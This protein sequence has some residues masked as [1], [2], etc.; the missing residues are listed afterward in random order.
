MK[1]NAM[2]DR[3]KWRPVFEAE[4]VAGGAAAPAPEPAAPEAPKT[5]LSDAFAGDPAKTAQAAEESKDA[6]ADEGKGGD[7]G[8]KTAAEAEAAAPFEVSVP[9]GMESHKDAFTGYTGA[10]NDFLK[11][12]PAATARDALA[13]AATYQADQVREAG[14]AMQAQFEATV[15]GW[16]A[17]AKKDAE[18][19][20]AAFDATVQSALAGLRAFGSP[21]LTKALNDSGLGSHPEVIRAFAK[22]GKLAQESPIIAGEGGKGNVSFAQSLYGKAK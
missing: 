13:W 6:K 17:E 18:I 4:G 2:F 1:G 12:N 8:D 5:T 3:M 9:E 22:V 10:V 20:G 21:G 16:E 19:G 7:G 11:A 15:K 14:N